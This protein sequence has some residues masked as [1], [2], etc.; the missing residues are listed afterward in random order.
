[1]ATSCSKCGTPL[2]AAAKSCRHCG[3]QVTVA[4]SNQPQYLAAPKKKRTLLM[5]CLGLL[6]AGFVVAVLAVVLIFYSLMGA[7]D[8]ATKADHYEIGNDKIPTVK[9]ALGGERKVTG[10]GTSTSNGVTKKEWT[11]QVPGTAQNSEMIAYYKYLSEKDGFL[12]LEDIDFS[13][14]TGTAKL[15]RNS[16]DGG[17]IVELQIKYDTGGYVITVSKRQGTITPNSQ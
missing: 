4:T 11:Y 13:G 17:Q 7:M 2:E 10:I 16:V 1:M 6:A 9:L 3:T 8:K 5:T 12:L 14:Q 15:G